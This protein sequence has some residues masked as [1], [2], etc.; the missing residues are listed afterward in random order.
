MS[1]QFLH[2]AQIRSAFEQVGRGA[3]SKAVRRQ[4]RGPRDVGNEPMDRRSPRTS[5]SLVSFS[6]QRVEPSR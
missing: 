6:T 3:V 5:I 2:R 4:V 1:E